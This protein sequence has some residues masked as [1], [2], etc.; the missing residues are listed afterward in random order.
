MTMNPAFDFDAAANRINDANRAENIMI[1]RR[2]L[3]ARSVA[4]TLAAA[5]RV[6][7]P[8]VRAVWG[9]GSTFE[10]GRPYRLDSDID[11]AIEGGDLLSLLKIVENTA[12]AIDLVDVSDSDDEFSRI[13]RRFGTLL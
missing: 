4:Q 6:A 12:F 9:F 10:A 3:E 1:E 2:R 8:A 5:M 13:V 7:D 11:L